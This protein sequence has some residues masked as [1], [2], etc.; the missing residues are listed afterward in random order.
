MIP[1]TT[2]RILL[3]IAAVVW[4]FAGTMLFTR[5]IGMMDVNPDS[6]WIRFLIS[7]ICGALFYGILFTRI[8]KKHVNRIIQLPVEQ[9]TVFSFFDKKGYIMMVGMISL[10]IFLRTSGIVA[11]F[12]LSVLYVTMGIPLFISSL[13]F[14]YSGLYY[15]SV[16]KKNR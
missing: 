12:Y 1:R 5:G 7:L 8:S 10:G 3:F 2:K 9:P 16:I 14:Y 15:S 6:F 13:R 11:P 4:T